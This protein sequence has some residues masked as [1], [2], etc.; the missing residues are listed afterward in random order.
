ML[1]YISS[2]SLHNSSRLLRFYLGFYIKFSRCV[3][4]GITK[5]TLYEFSIEIGVEMV[6]SMGSG[7][8]T[9]V[10]RARVAIMLVVALA[11]LTLLVSACEPQL[12]A[13]VGGIANVGGVPVRND[14]S[15]TTSSA[16]P[17]VKA[18]KVLQPGEY[19]IEVKRVKT[20]SV[21]S[22]LDDEGYL[23][24]L[25]V[26]LELR[27]PSSVEVAIKVT[28]NLFGNTAITVSHVETLTPGVNVVY[29]SLP[30]RVNPDDIVSLQVE[31]TPK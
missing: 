6:G 27:A 29:I 22:V 30:Q 24:G 11:L 12:L 25:Y 3:T 18:V 17:N 14:V 7:S 1:R 2:V 15:T 26:Y 21:D 10:G 28:I 8:R 20:L 13:I 4:Y 5:V 19:Q 9:K 16:P 23:K 31:A